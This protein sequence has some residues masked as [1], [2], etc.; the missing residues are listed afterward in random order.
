MVMVAVVYWLPTG[1]LLARADWLGAKVGGAV[2]ALAADNNNH[3]ST[4]RHYQLFSKQKLMQTSSIVTSTAVMYL[5]AVLN[6]S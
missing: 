5:N 3:V 2:S 1:R 4:S 6:S